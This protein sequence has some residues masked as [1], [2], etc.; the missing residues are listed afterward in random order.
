MRAQLR[1]R[2]DQFMGTAIVILLV[3]IGVVI[4][5]GDQ[6]GLGVNDYGPVG[7]AGAHSNIHIRFNEPVDADAVAQRF[8]TQ[9]AVGGKWSVSG[10]EVIFHPAQPFTVN[11]DYSLTLKAGL[12]GTDQRPLKAP[13][14]CQFRVRHPR[15]AYL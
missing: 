9:P 11:Q 7:L 5:R 1:S 10:N 13:I 14:N 4:W 2:F 3:L 12:A 6:I 15:S 8:T